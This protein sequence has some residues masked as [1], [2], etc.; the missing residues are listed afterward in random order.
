MSTLLRTLIVKKTQ[1]VVGI[2]NL[3]VQYIYMYFMYDI[4][5]CT[6]LS[7]KKPLVA[8]KG[9]GTVS[10]CRR[11]NLEMPSF[12]LDNRVLKEPHACIIFF[13]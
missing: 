5:S 8:N 2:Y 12:S 4:M 1:D 3:H 6:V 11:C 10:N 13:E 7:R 9:H